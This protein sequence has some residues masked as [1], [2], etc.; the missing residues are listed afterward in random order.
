MDQSALLKIITCRLVGGHQNKLTCSVI[1]S[2]NCYKSGL[3]NTLLYENEDSIMADR[4]FTVEDLLEPIN[5]RLIP[6]F[7][8]GR[9]QMS[10][11][12][13]ILTVNIIRTHS[14]GMYD[15]QRLKKLLDT[16]LCS[17][18]IPSMK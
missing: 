6:S 11:E 3:R 15:F 18:M 1:L 2:R 7:L 17:H 13:I 10:Q 5:V 8:S 4:E 16:G 9:E 14:C 12:E